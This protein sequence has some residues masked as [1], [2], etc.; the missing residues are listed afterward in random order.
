MPTENESDS[1]P[2]PPE[3]SCYKCCVKKKAPSVLVCISCG[4]LFHFSCS[5]RKKCLVIDGT[6]VICC[7]KNIA[8]NSKDTSNLNPNQMENYLL[9]VVLQQLQDQNL[10]LKED[11][12]QLKKDLVDTTKKYEDIKNRGLPLLTVGSMEKRAIS[13][14]NVVKSEP[15]I[16]VKPKKDQNSRDTKK[17]IRRKVNPDGINIS[18]FRQGSNG[19]VIIGT[20]NIKHMDSLKN[21]LSKEMGADY[22]VVV[23]TKKRPKVKVVNINSS[24]VDVG[25]ED[26]NITDQLVKG[27]SLVQDEG[28]HMR[29]VKKT[30]NK[31]K[32]VD[33]IIEMDS[34][35]HSRIL[36]QE[37]IK[38]G[39]SRARVFNHISILQ[40]YK[41]MS[42]NHYAK[43]C[44]SDVVTCS[45]CGGDHSYRQ[46]NTPTVKCCNCDR[47]NK[48]NKN[49]SLDIGHSALD[50]T[51]PCRNDIASFETASRGKE[52]LMAIVTLTLAL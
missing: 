22:E 23:P 42:Y 6:R 48:K 3:P 27:N 24:N 52:G 2:E 37:K 4:S 40:C 14:A 43:D 17:E 34:K 8:Y 12:G 29:I 21:Q 47:K 25:D 45:Q 11:S 46:C 18:K 51:C 39:W 15:V 33:L 50:R 9:K 7:S 32:N 16:I 38:I 10:Q 5:Q 44:N 41:C 31:Y 13:D 26:E 19:T 1:D 20:E 28:F 30:E 36:T 35:T 49:S